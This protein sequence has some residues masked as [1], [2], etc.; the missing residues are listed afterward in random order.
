MNDYALGEFISAVFLGQVP[1]IAGGVI[2]F[3]LALLVYTSLRDGL[4]KD[5]S[6]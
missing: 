1:L 2:V 3:V 4:L 6:P 5:V